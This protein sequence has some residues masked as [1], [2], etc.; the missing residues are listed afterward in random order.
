MSITYYNENDPAIAEWLR[1]LVK[2]DAVAFGHVD[3]RSIE[4]VTPADLAGYTQCHFFAGIG[5]WSYALRLAGWPDNR[6]VWTGSCPCQPFS[7]AGAKRGVHDPRHLWPHW[8]W[9]IDQC[10]PS[11]IFGEQVASPDGRRWLAGVFADLEAMGYQ[12]A[13]AD[14]CAAGVGAP[15]I[16]QRLWWMADRKRNGRRERCADTSGG[17]H[18]PS[19]AGRSGRLGNAAGHDERR[20]TVSGQNRQ[21]LSP[22]GSGGASRLGIANSGG[23]PPRQQTAPTARHRDSVEPT[24]GTG[25]LCDADEPRSQGRRVLPERSRERAPW[26]A[27]LGNWI[28]CADGKARRIEP[29][30]KPLV[31]GFPGRVGLL[32][33][34]GNAIAPELAAQFIEAA[35]CCRKYT[36]ERK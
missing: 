6:P 29:G 26:A 21:G 31:N 16:R 4:D 32:R 24:N 2:A 14:L 33:G 30:I 36:G 12:R 35:D 9:L 17:G 27:S 18:R 19:N 25:G 20:H 15:H 3:D 8:R 1:E 22:R 7:Q 28:A 34:Y 11:T 13:G 5:G 23:R 10:R